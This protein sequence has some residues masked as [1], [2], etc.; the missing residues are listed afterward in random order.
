M[1]DY[2]IQEED[3]SEL[4]KD[5]KIVIIRAEFNEEYTK[6]LEDINIAFLEKKGFENIEKFLVPWALEIPWCTN[7]ILSE[8]K[9]D[10]V[11]CLWVVI[12]WATPHFEHVCRES[13]RG[14]MDLTMKYNTPIINGILTCNNEAQVK[15]RIKNVYAIS[16]LKT[17]REYKKI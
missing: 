11:I 9:A 8:I 7:K 14:V 1:S 17:L 6:S 16:G 5:I 13:S 10:L 4:A 2:Q 12:E 15:E 3:F